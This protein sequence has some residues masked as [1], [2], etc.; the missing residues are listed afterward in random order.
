MGILDRFRARKNEVVVPP[1]SR[2]APPR[3]LREFVYLDESSLR[4]L[5]SSQT[6]EVTESRSEQSGDSRQGQ[7][8][9]T[10][11]ANMPMLT[12]GELKSSFQT[13]NSSTLQTS[14]KAT[15]QSWFRELHG[16]PGLRLIEPGHSVPEITIVEDLLAVTDPSILLP[17]NAL[18]RG[19]LV[20]FRVK[21][22]ADPV[23]HLGTVMSEMTGIL[24][25]SPELFAGNSAVN[26]IGEAQRINK[27]L[28]RLLA[29]LIPIRAE[30]IDYV[31]VTIEGV[32]YLTNKAAT[33][34]LG[35]PH[36]RVEIVGVT[37]HDAYWKDIRRVLFA[38]AEFT[39]LCRIARSGLHATW[40]PV[41]LGDLFHQMAPSLVDDIN[42]ASLTPF[43]DAASGHKVNTNELKLAHALKLYADL[44]RA[45]AG[46]QLTGDQV[47]ELDRMVA[48]L[49]S[50]AATAEGHRSAF[51]LMRETIAAMLP[52]TSSADDDAGL[53]EEART[54]SG[55]PL[56]PSL[57][58]SETTSIGAPL[59]LP[60]DA[61]RLLDVE[62][63][64]IYW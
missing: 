53:R 41:K 34:A 31:T 17:T 28:Q 15:V 39:M 12:K 18:D 42:A 5:L 23:F 35:L 11:G 32:E 56:F 1:V 16:L 43:R 22:S 10:L 54:A 14:R 25:E 62:V 6:G 3:P 61:P 58:A 29:G 27:V 37:E 24:D 44:L 8:E 36:Q 46:Q 57:T 48:L 51:T 33:A 19:K 47:D 21:L 13:A 38:Q 45:E 7:I 26:A 9:A 52:L 64:A 49:T 30:A 2:D 55:L 59:D 20:E 60:D 50:R 4:S 40:T 63:V